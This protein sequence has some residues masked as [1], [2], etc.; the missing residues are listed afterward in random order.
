MSKAWS[1]E[2]VLS[3]T[4][5]LFGQVV[6]CSLNGLWFWASFLLSVTGSYLLFFPPPRHVMLAIL[7]YATREIIVGSSRSLKLRVAMFLPP[8]FYSRISG[9]D[10][11]KGGRFVTAPDWYPKI[12]ANFSL[13][14]LH[15]IMAYLFKL[16]I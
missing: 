11:C 6:P 9:R 10:S 12:W 7:S 1:P 2:V 16:L 5:P 3:S 13:F 14:A 4:R 15:C 8:Y